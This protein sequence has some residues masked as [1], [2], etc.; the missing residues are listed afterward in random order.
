M[1]T[2]LLVEAYIVVRAMVA[3]EF[4][5]YFTLNFYMLAA[6]VIAVLQIVVLHAYGF[7]SAEYLYSYYYGDA[8][9][10]IYLYLAI[11]G[12]YQHVFQEMAVSKYIRVGAVL[13]LAATAG[14]SYLVVH[15]NKGN[16]TGRWV[17]E[18]SQNLYF[19]GVVLTYVLWGAVMQLKETRLRI[20]QLVLSLGVYFSAYAATYA[21][22]HMFPQMDILKQ[23]PPFLGV[24]LALA[25][26]YTF[27]QI[28]E[29]A[30]LAT[31]R[32]AAHNK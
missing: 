12:L 16:L 30:R 14:F 17:V 10:T 24:F 3:R 21:L 5:R 23:V 11:L 29:E 8:V 27:T 20:V 32:V 2:S 4:F 26:A 15:E 31:A 22:R 19:V 25:W 6:A 9:L 18:L 7:S 13:L 1:I 28:P